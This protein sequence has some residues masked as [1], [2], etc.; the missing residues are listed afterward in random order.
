MA[1]KREQ[2]QDDVRLRVMRLLEQNPK[3]TTREIA[4]LVGISNGS[5]YYVVTALINKGFV[6]IVNFK[7]NPRKEK[8]F[9]LLTTEGIK[10]KTSL[11]HKFIERKTREYVDL[12]KEIAILKKET[13]MVEENKITNSGKNTN[14]KKQ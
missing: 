8:Y 4:D 11:A 14:F 9:Y 6:K 12:R 5:A 13:E 10:E 1:S 3:M 2:Q 7:N